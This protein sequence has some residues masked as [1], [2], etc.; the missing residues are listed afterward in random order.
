MKHTYWQPGSIPRI[1]HNPL[2]SHSPRESGLP[3]GY[4]NEHGI[5][6]ERGLFWFCVIVGLS[7]FT[8]WAG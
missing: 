1:K 7:L 5:T 6:F 2:Q 4:F 8:G 3:L